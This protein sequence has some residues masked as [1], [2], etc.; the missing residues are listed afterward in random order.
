MRQPPAADLGQPARGRAQ[1]ALAQPE[2]PP[3]RARQRHQLHVRR[4]RVHRSFL[5]GAAPATG[6]RSGYGTIVHVLPPVGERKEPPVFKAKRRTVVSVA[7]VA[8]VL[9]AAA[10]AVTFLT[11]GHGKADAG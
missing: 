5:R 9:L 11:Q 7:A 6:P 8:A 3:V 4:G 2:G 10:L 1:T